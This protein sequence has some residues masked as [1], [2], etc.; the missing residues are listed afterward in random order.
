MN[1]FDFQIT[2]EKII[3]ENISFRKIKLTLKKSQSYFKKEQQ[4]YKLHLL[5]NIVGT[6]QCPV[7][8]K[9]YYSVTSLL[10]L[11]RVAWAAAKRAMGTLKGE[12][13][14]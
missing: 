7:P 3:K 9:K 10:I 14:T 8:T 11:P 6:G 2:P 5:K 13:L 12:Q 4:P 1:I